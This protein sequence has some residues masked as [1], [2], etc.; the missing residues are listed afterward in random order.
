[1]HVCNSTSR[2]RPTHKYGHT[3]TLDLIISKDNDDSFVTSCHVH[4]KSY[5]DHHFLSC[6][7]DVGKS[8]LKYVTSVSRNFRSLDKESFRSGIAEAFVDFKI[9]GSA[10]TQALFYKYA[11][12][13]VLDNLCPSTKQTHKFSLTSSIYTDEIYEAR[14]NRR[15]LENLWSRSHTI[16]DHIRYLDQI[17]V[18]GSLVRKAK[19]SYYNDQLSNADTKSIFRVLNTLLNS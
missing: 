9:D 13:T 14:R 15:R 17:H 3:L 6:V 7:L 4:E 2:V 19:S 1:M 12:C 18:L 5:S 10:D 16:G 11:I 8:K